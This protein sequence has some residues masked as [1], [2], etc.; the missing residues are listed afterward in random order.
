MSR[1]TRRHVLL[2][3]AA[4]V[5]LSGC[6]SKSAPPKTSPSPT[7]SPTPSASAP[8]V[9]AAVLGAAMENLLVALYDTAI[10]AATDGKLGV[11][12]AAAVG[13][14]TTTRAHHAD[15]AQAWA[16]LLDQ[17]HAPAVDGTPLVNADALIAS[18]GRVKS[19]A[20]LGPV[21]AEAERV[22]TATYLT[23]ITA[24]ALES[25]VTTGV[26]IAPVEAAHA[27]AIALLTGQAPLTRPPAGQLF[28]L[29]GALTVADLVAAP[30]STVP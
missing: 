12:P 29:R 6:R 8:D 25:V 21:A 14:L 10:S 24:V 9:Q 3:S 18:V 16:A 28:D 30:P 27:S 22:A 17:N 5:M 11:V 1:P 7:P 26:S 2:G 4:A 20:E 15:H 23:S 13:Y 19:F